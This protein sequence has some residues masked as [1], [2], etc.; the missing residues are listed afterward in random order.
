MEEMANAAADRALSAAAALVQADRL[1]EALA[2]LL[3]AWRGSLAPALADAI[4]VV[5][6]R[7]ADGQPSLSGK[8]ASAKREWKRTAREQRAADLDRLLASWRDV[9]AD[10]VAVRAELLLEWPA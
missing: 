3:Q 6:A 9:A 7:I 8:T 10:E 4:D 2:G 5:G 1:A